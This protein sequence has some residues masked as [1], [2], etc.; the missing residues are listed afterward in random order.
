MRVRL[1]I[2]FTL[3][4]LWAGAFP[5]T[6]PARAGTIREASDAIVNSSTRT[7]L[8][9]IPDSGSDLPPFL[10]GRRDVYLIVTAGAGYAD[11]RVLAD[12]AT[13]ARAVADALNTAAAGTALAG[14]TVEYSA[15][16]Y[17]AAR[18]RHTS[19]RWWRMA[20]ANTV[21]MGALIA[22]LRRAGFVPHPLLRVPRFARA[23]GVPVATVVGTRNFRWY[24]G[25]ALAG[26]GE[27]VVSERLRPLDLWPFAL[28]LLVALLSV[29]GF[30]FALRRAGNEGEPVEARRKRFEA[31]RR[32]PLFGMVL[33]I[34]AAM[35]MM[36]STPAKVLA[37]LWWGQ[38]SAALIFGPFVMA[39][40]LPFVFLVVV[41]KRRE[42]ALFGKPETGK[43]WLSEEEK[44]LQ[45]KI[46]KWSALPHL[47]GIAGV[48]AVMFL[49][50]HRSPLYSFLHPLSQI[51]M[52]SGAALVSLLFRKQTAALTR[53]SVDDDLTFRARR[54]GQLLGARP[55]EVWVEESSRATHF[56][57]SYREKDHI[58]VSRKLRDE[59]SPA[60]TDFV[61]AQHVASLAGKRRGPGVAGLAPILPLMLL[62]PGAFILM[63]Y[64]PGGSPSLI[65][66]P[67]F[68]PSIMLLFF[69]FLIPLLLVPKQ[70][71]K[72]TLARE[73]AAD[74]KALEA[75]GDLAAALSALEKLETLPPGV[76]AGTRATAHV[77]TAAEA[78]LR[79]VRRIALERAAEELGLSPAP[80]S[81]SAWPSAARRAEEA[82]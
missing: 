64:S 18:L 35:F 40:L 24:D 61:L 11:V 65:L 57:G 49:V 82:P 28:L 37:D 6:I 58:V 9:L 21:P 48:G 8:G 60:E 67:W 71:A 22:G 2:V 50:P 74:R 45:K 7:I 47:I 56:I 34:P 20:G 79:K 70:A 46:Q 75:T 44:S 59:F 14:D 69:L 80:P 39:M 72:V 41:A 23:A 25:H 15:D 78:A 62:L 54:F 76:G 19:G 31:V 53:K 13:S 1:R 32:I 81:A 29:V 27:V 51:L 77:E 52:G 66:S 42:L 5:L 12:A 73:Q 63:R 33:A 38:T 36:L 10:P 30:G 17:A 3:S 4:L 16:S 68:L 26:S 43:P 55:R